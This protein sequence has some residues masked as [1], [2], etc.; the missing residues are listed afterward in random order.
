[1]GVGTIPSSG[2][3]SRWRVGR[4]RRAAAVLLV[5]ILAGCGSGV[6][7]TPPVLT[8]PVGPAASAGPSQAAPSQ[9]APGFTGGDVAITSITYSEDPASPFFAVVELGP[10]DAGISRLDVYRGADGRLSSVVAYGP[11]GVPAVITFDPAG[12]PLRMDASGYVV[13]FTYPASDIEVVITAPDGSVV[14]QRG[15]LDRG[16]AVPA[17]AAPNARLASYPQAPLPSG[18]VEWPLRF[19]SHS[20]FDLDVTYTGPNPDLWMRHVT[21]PDVRCTPVSPGMTCAAQVVWPA[22]RQGAWL[23]PLDRT[24]SLLVSSYASAGKNPNLGSDNLIWRTH[25][26]CDAYK[27]LVD[28]LV[29]GT[30]VAVYLIGAFRAVKA[31][32]VVVAAAP[33]LALGLVVLAGAI[34]AWQQWGP[35]SKP[36][37]NSVPNLQQMQDK[38]FSDRDGDTVTL[39]VTASDDCVQHPET[40]WRV[41]DPT[42]QTLP[43]QP[44]LSKNRAQFNGPSLDRISYLPTVGTITFQAADCAAEMVGS[45]DLA[46]SAATMGMPKSSADVWAKM[47]ID[48][49]IL[50]K[51]KRAGVE[52]TSPIDVTGKFTLTSASPD[53]CGTSL[54]NPC[55]SS[56]S[57]SGTLKGTISQAG[58]YV[59]EGLAT[60]SV[61]NSRYSCALPEPGLTVKWAAL[62]DETSLNGAIE[63]PGESGRPPMSLIFTVRGK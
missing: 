6:P 34:R 21:F 52:A 45:F 14:R 17:P 47:F 27:P 51:V 31:A 40:G 62:G 44:F 56:Q 35:S 10:N 12:R 49:Q 3:A 57:I 59:A 11:E 13:E 29:A 25:A 20:V 61:V 23:A 50:L 1:V 7:A 43:F 38:F 22:Y 36:D 16:A 18:M 58:G 19:A 46:A 53:C 39:A 30:G 4:G 42:T 8:E 41:K 15:P 9:A 63:M 32:V 26:D 37:C 60:I 24:P 28:S 2:G 48:N 33:R 5:V 55:S 54:P